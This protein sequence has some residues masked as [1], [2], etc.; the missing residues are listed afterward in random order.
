MECN[1]QARIIYLL[2]HGSILTKS[3]E[4]RYIGQSDVPLS[5]EGVRQAHMLQA[6]FAGKGISAVFCSD[7][8]RSI[9][10]ARIIC[11]GLTDNLVIRADLREISMGDWEGKTFNEIAQDYPE[12][13]AERGN[14]ISNY[15]IP[16]AESFEKCRSRMA[17]AFEDIIDSTAGD[18]IIVGHAGINRVLLCHILGMP[19]A[20][21][22]RIYQDYGCINILAG[23]GGQYRVKLLNGTHGHESQRE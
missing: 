9:A 1:K 21:L 5:G 19:L 16:G 23:S 13:Y 11:A 7:L 15:R 2:R 17:A 22:F 18:I 8:I 10:T 3:C 4:R 20:N 14:N 6:E 12:E